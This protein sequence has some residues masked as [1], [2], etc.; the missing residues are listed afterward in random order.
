MQVSQVAA[1][2]AGGGDELLG[3]LGVAL[4]AAAE[5]V[6]VDDAGLELEQ[7]QQLLGAFLVHVRRRVPPEHGGELAVA[8]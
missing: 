1:R 3:R 5:A 7:G 8:G 6:V 2:V 4:V